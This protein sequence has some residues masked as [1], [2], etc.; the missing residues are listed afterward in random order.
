MTLVESWF[1][2]SAPSLIWDSILPACRQDGDMASQ[3]H[4]G[5]Q[6]V[7]AAPRYIDMWDSILPTCLCLK[8]EI[9]HSGLQPAPLRPQPQPQQLVWWVAPAPPQ[10]S[11][12]K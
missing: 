12:R 3:W 10:V 11:K 1:H 5:L 7:A 8:V 6:P 4:P 9:W 2:A